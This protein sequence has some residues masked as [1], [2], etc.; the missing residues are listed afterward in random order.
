MVGH[1]VLAFILAGGKGSRLEVLT[2]QRAKPAM[3]FAGLYRLIDFAL[4]NCMHSYLSDVWVVEQYHLHSLNEHL[5]NGRPWDLD[6]TYGGLQV[7][8]PYESRGEH[9]AEGGFAEGNADAIYRNRNLIREFNPDLLVVMSADHVY[10]LDYRDV[11]A[12]HLDRRADVTMVTT[13]IPRAE[14]SRF[15]SVKVVD[16]GRVVEFAHKPEHPE[17]DIVTTEVFLFNAHTLLET[18]DGLAA[19]Q[20]RQAKSNAKA[21][22]Q[23]E[24]RLRDLGH[25]LIPKLVQAGRVFEYRLHSYWRDVGTVESYWQAHMDLLAP[26]P[27]LVLDDVEWPILTAGAQRLPARIHET[28]RIANSL[29]SPGCTVRGLVAHSVLAPGVVVHEGAVVRDSVVLHGAVIE[30]RATVD[31]AIIDAG[32]RVGE[33]AVVGEQRNSQGNA[34]RPTSAEIAIIG[35]KTQVPAGACIA[36]DTRITPGAMEAKVLGEPPL[37]DESSAGRAH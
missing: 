4:S 8:P 19:N 37:H 30:A 20:T 33:G 10:K 18:L 15:G 28:A 5:A 35:Q 22:S 25:E 34:H 1:K 12:Q 7:L 24:P 16:A 26:T 11:I 2:E 21:G 17:S 9:D 13:Q 14:A 27:G 31:C 6:R 29:I 36:A 23:Q 32:V 3:P